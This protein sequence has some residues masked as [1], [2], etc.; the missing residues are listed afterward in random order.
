MRDVWEFELADTMDVFS[1]LSRFMDP[2]QFATTDLLDVPSWRRMIAEQNTHCSWIETFTLTANAYKVNGYCSKRQLAWIRQQ[3]RG[4]DNLTKLQQHLLNAQ[5]AWSTFQNI[6]HSIILLT[7][8]RRTKAK[9]ATY[10]LRKLK[11]YK[12]CHGCEPDA[13]KDPKVSALA[14]WVRKYRHTQMVAAILDA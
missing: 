4:I 7:S 2:R 6:K 5:T 3:Y 8:S 9:Y 10:Y 13:S 11:E 12:N 14:R 1:W